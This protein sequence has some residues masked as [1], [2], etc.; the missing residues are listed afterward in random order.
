MTS[1]GFTGAVWPAHVSAGRWVEGPA[2]PPHGASPGHELHF[3]SG[4][5]ALVGRQGLERLTLGLK[6]WSRPREENDR[7][8]PQS[9]ILCLVLLLVAPASTLA[10]DFRPLNAG[11]R[12]GK[13]GSTMFGGDEDEHFQPMRLPRHGVALVSTSS[14][15]GLGGSAPRLMGT[16]GVLIRARSGSG[17]RRSDSCPRLR[18][19]GR[20]PA[21]WMPAWGSRA[22]PGTSSASKI[23]AG[24]FP[25]CVDVRRAR[26][27]LPGLRHWL[28]DGP[29]VRRQDLR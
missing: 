3:T 12:G 9:P 5:R 15:S 14:E 24:R 29:H 8:R 19:Q 7:M 10:G 28:S 11:I 26:S 23:S 25:I 4:T 13:T 1:A 6:S 16:T 22:C 17:L 20:H 27:R 18:P 2:I 21:L